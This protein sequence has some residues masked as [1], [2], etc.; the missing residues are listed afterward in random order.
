MEL[1]EFERPLVP[2]SVA[3]LEANVT[4]LN[5]KYYEIKK[6]EK[7]IVKLKS[8][9]LYKIL[10]S[11]DL[12][13]SG[14]QPIRH[15]EP[16]TACKVDYHGFV[17]NNETRTL[18]GFAGTV[19]PVTMYPGLA[20]EGLSEVL[21]LMV[22]GDKWQ[23][24]IP[25]DL[26][27]EHKGRRGLR[28]EPDVLL[29]FDLE[30]TEMSERS[31]GLFGVRCDVFTK[32]NC[33]EKDAGYIDKVAEWDEERKRKEIARLSVTLGTSGHLAEEQKAWMRRRVYLL[34]TMVGPEEESIEPPSQNDE[35]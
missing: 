2:T 32:E 23:I 6:Q 18:K 25:S 26:A 4:E 5:E 30:L 10:K 19:E 24:T 34:K 33:V 14:G 35:L 22:V 11:G 17:F 9:V 8:G 31:D 15:P 3:G 27:Y 29:I 16:D 28:V 21:P 1:L 7:D 12:F 13:G 20:M